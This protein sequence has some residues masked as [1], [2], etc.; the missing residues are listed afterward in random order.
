MTA[1]DRALQAVMVSVLV[2]STAA[3]VDA[4]GGTGSKLAPIT[5]AELVSTLHA[6]NQVEIQAGKM[7]QAR[8][9]TDAV[10]QYGATLTRDHE[11]A[12]ANLQQLAAQEKL[13][14]DANMPSAAQLAIRDAKG[15]MA[16]L[17]TVGG[18]AFDRE[19]ATT[20][21]QQQQ[22]AIRFVDR[23]RRTITDAKLRAL[24]GQVEPNLRE[25]EQ[26]GSNILSGF[27]AAPR[28]PEGR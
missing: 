23:A 16:N 8:G 24:L 12:D 10:K 5:A 28:R 26:I 20:M 6:V 14:L 3:R 18:E 2:L 1:G 7:A 13:A 21:V 17:S 19:F 15:E 4:E 27:A 9:A 11:A 22:A 25:H